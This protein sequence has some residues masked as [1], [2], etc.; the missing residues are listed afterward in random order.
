M[1]GA[2]SAE[3]SALLDRWR[4]I[5]RGREPIRSLFDVATEMGIAPTFACL[6]CL[7]A[8]LPITPPGTT[9]NS[10]EETAAVAVADWR[11]VLLGA[12]PPV[13]IEVV[14]RRHG[15]TVAAMKAALRK[16]GLGVDQPPQPTSR[17]V[18]APGKRR[19]VKPRSGALVEEW[20][21]MLEAWRPGDEAIY[22]CRLAGKHGL[23]PGG[24][25]AAVVR[26][27]LPISWTEKI[28]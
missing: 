28:T 9:M 3:M 15:L 19:G 16:A 4:D 2:L 26:D 6:T 17:L 5:L 10:P 18:N 25:C 1:S 23:T 24:A 14:A 11:R 7:G 27:G 13:A 8:R 20:R 22:V 12:E 21:S